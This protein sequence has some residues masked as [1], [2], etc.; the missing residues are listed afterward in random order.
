MN[1]TLQVLDSATSKD[2]TAPSN[3]S[4]SVGIASAEYNNHIVSRTMKGVSAYSAT[5]GA[6]S[7][8]SGRISY[9]FGFKG[10]AMSIDTA[11]SSSLVGSHVAATSVWDGASVAAI[12]AGIGLLLN[13]DPTAMFQKAGMLAP[14]GRCKTLDANADGYVRGE[15]AAVLYYSVAQNI[16]QQGSIVALLVSTAVNQDGR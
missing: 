6:L 8:A 11:C 10:Q 3:T 12:T 4:V 7:V 5:G 2:C 15:S 14:D 9:T 16:S 1:V 13:P